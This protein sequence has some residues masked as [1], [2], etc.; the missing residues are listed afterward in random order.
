MAGK[1]R[2]SLAITLDSRQ[3]SA[4]ICSHFLTRC[5]ANVAASGLDHYYLSDSSRRITR[6]AANP[7]ILHVSPILAG[8][9]ARGFRSRYRKIEQ[10]IS[11]LLREKHNAET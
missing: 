6:R 1:P 5:E 8:V 2:R 3:P 11:S 7:P 9:R 10:F 4:R